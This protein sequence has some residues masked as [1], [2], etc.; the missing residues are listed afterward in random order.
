[1]STTEEIILFHSSP[2]IPSLVHA[3][4]LD[5]CGGG[6]AMGGLPESRPSS[7]TPKAAPNIPAVAPANLVTQKP[8]LPQIQRGKSESSSDDQ[9]NAILF[10]SIFKFLAKAILDYDQF[11]H[12]SK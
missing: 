2:V 5:Q 9:G 7:A 4:V 3:N 8:Q 1:M 6:G 10:G 11:G 12:F